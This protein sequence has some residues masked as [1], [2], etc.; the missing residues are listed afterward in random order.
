MTIHSPENLEELIRIINLNKSHGWSQFLTFFRG[1]IFDWPIRPNLTRNNS[2]SDEEILEIEKKA[3]NEFNSYSDG[4][5]ILDHFEKDNTEFAQD[6][7]NLFQAQHLGLYTRL[8]DWTQ[9][10]RSS[11]FFAVDDVNKNCARDKGVIWIYKCPYYPQD[12]MLIN[13]NLDENYHFFNVS[14]FNLQK[15]YLIK[16]YS[17]FSEDVENFAGEIRK[18]R[19]N[20]S[21]IISTSEDISTPIEDL[22]YIKEHL[23]K[24]L[25]KPSLKDEIIEYLGENIRDYIYYSSLENNNSEMERIS[26]L[27]EQTNKKYFWPK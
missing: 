6:W 23:I 25:I 17:Q 1:Q 4:L 24:V 11:M 13:F 20:G 15:A 12:D 21:F 10:E 9:D 19:Q 8:T 5:N 26:T 14:P 3:Y 18:F 27:T 2:L 22:N 7:Q 16:H